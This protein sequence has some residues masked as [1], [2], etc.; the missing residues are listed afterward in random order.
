MG[1][2]QI[3]VLAASTAMQGIGAWLGGGSG[4]QR[5]PFAQF[6]M[7][8]GDNEAQYVGDML[9][10]ML[11]DARHRGFA[12]V[13]PRVD[14]DVPTGHTRT[15]PLILGYSGRGYT[16]GGSDRGI[17]GATQTLPGMG[18]P[19]AEDYHREQQRLSDIAWEKDQAARAKHLED[20]SDRTDV[21][22][23][24]PYVSTYKGLGSPGTFVGG[25][26]IRTEPHDMRQYQSPGSTSRTDQYKTEHPYWWVRGGGYQETADPGGLA[27]IQGGS[28]APPPP[29]ASEGSG[30]VQGGYQAPPQAPPPEGGGYQSSG[31]QYGDRY[32]EVKALRDSVAERGK[33]E[34][35]GGDQQ[36]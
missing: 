22:E 2:A 3:A 6:G 25:R 4:D 28:N 30:Y 27:Y 20:E 19:W 33:L 21:G 36:V 24:V 34:R 23:S 18:A 12:K 35:G 15:A 11:S 13:S 5:K 14:F 29:P 1:W 32:E 26:Q 9:K 17:Y 7:E 16:A 10:G 8:M 31:G